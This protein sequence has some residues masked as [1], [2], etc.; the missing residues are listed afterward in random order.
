MSGKT[1]TAV[2][3]GSED[4]KT[5]L[6]SGLV[7]GQW[8]FYR[9]RGIVFDPWKGETD[10]GPSAWV[11][12]DFAKFK[13][14][15]MGTRNCA[16]VWDEGTSTGGRD[17]DN[18]DLF[19]AIRHYHPSFYFIGHRY[20]AMLPIMRGSLTEVLLAV[21]DRDDAD[22]WAKVM[23][24]DRVREMATKLGKYEFLFKKKHVPP[25]VVKFTPEQIRQG[26][27]LT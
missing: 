2:I 26:I 22:A 24:D 20:D 1:R 7:R 4:G 21:R 13:R 5:F 14:A 19:T 9:R 27:R 15:V 25:K 8:R 18:V 6:T 12:D 17:R 10:W 16:V 3:G 11:T 23:V